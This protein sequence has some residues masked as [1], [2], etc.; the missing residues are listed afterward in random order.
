M[1]EATR[2][3]P[4]SCRRNES[5]PTVSHRYAR[6]WRVERDG[7][8]RD[9]RER[10]V[11]EGLRVVPAVGRRG[12]DCAREERAR[13][14]SREEGLAC[15]AERELPRRGERGDETRAEREGARTPGIDGR[16][17]GRIRRRRLRGGVSGKRAFTRGIDTLCRRVVTRV[18]ATVRPYGQGAGRRAAGET[19][20]PHD[21]QWQSAP[22]RSSNPPHLRNTTARRRNRPLRHEARVRATVTRVT[23]ARIV[24][25]DHGAVGRRWAHRRRR[26]SHRGGRGVRVG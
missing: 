15:A 10:V 17:D 14:R 18:V 16:I 20:E 5:P 23:Q 2:T 24:H 8:G 13:R 12:V 22:A 3:A 26:R 19:A 7:G 4:T 11:R 6:P 21:G 1:A 25:A 9:G